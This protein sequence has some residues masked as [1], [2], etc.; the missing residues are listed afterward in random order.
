MPPG[1]M[2]YKT[3]HPAQAE[4]LDID[5]RLWDHIRLATSFIARKR[6]PLAPQDPAASAVVVRRPGGEPVVVV[7]LDR[8][9]G[10]SNPE[11]LDHPDASDLCH[12]FN[13]TPRESEVALLL[14]QRM[15][16]REIANRL[17][18]SFHTARSHTEKIMMKLGVRSKNDVRI[19]LGVTE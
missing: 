11:L 14:A 10:P 16:C 1:T 4:V 7:L 17:A 5:E 15:S 2:A 19:R 6:G 9:T 3:A 8:Q 12:R 18:V 13:L